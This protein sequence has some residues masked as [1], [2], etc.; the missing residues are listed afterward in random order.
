MKRTIA[1]ILFFLVLV[2]AGID[3]HA[4]RCGDRLVHP[5][6]TFADVLSKCG[7][8]VLKQ[9]RQETV[10]EK[11]DREMKRRTTIA[12]DEWTYNLGP[13]SFLR[14]LTFQNGKLIT[15]EAGDY[16]Y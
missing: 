16:G 10:S 5:G 6:D 4:F 13:D 12:I 11:T 15:I 8:P 9:S 2:L 1:G 14:Y 7:E 3:A